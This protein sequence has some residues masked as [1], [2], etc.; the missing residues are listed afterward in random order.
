MWYYIVMD[1]KKLNVTDTL[2]LIGELEHTRRHCLRSAVSVDN[3]E[4]KFFYM[5]TAKQCQDLR[6]AI[7]KKNFP[8]KTTDWCLV[9]CAASMRQVAYETANDDDFILKELD[10]LVDSIMEHA[11]GMDLSECVACKQDQNSE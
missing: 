11:T 10:D 6:R 8:V 3:E 2:T 4:D 1:Y 7:M 5:V 9:K